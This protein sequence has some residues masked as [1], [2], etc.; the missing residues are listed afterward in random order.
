MALFLMGLTIWLI[1]FGII[2]GQTLPYDVNESQFDNGNYEPLE[3]ARLV[4]S[5]GEP[6]V[7]VAMWL[8][9][10]SLLWLLA[11][12]VWKMVFVIRWYSCYYLFNYS[13]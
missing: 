10:S 8:V 5:T 3:L 9:S 12:G 11:D 13:C 2:K 7:L 4:S 6:F 1:L